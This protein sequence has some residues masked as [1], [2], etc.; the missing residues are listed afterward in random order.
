MNGIEKSSDQLGI[1]MVWNSRPP[2]G[3]YGFLTSFRHTGIREDCVMFFDE[4]SLVSPDE[5]IAEGSLVHYDVDVKED[6]PKIK[7]V[8]V[9]NFFSHDN[10]LDFAVEDVNIFGRFLSEIQTSSAPVLRFIREKFSVKDL[11]FL[12]RRRG[13]NEEP[14]LRNGVEDIIVER[15]NLIIGGHL[16]YDKV[17]FANIVLRNQT[18]LFLK[19]NPQNSELRYLNR[20]LLEDALACEVQDISPFPD[21]STSVVQAEILDFY[22]DEKRGRLK[23]QSGL[24]NFFY[25]IFPDDSLIPPSGTKVQC[26]IH[27]ISYGG[28]LFAYDIWKTANKIGATTSKSK[29]SVEQVTGPFRISIE[30]HTLIL[31]NR[32]HSTIPPRFFNIL[33]KMFTKDEIGYSVRASQA[34]YDQVAILFEKGKLE[35]DGSVNLLSNQAG[36]LSR[37]PAFCFQAL[38]VQHFQGSSPASHTARRPEND[39]P[40]FDLP[41]DFSLTDPE[42]GSFCHGQINASLSNSLSTRYAA[43]FL[44]EKGLFKFVKPVHTS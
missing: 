2:V 14:M 35:E 16:I 20:L 4:S 29:N 6:R 10:R 26:R 3:R 41:R 38:L 25:H 31:P 39:L 8:R 36:H 40:G 13:F 12:H 32:T 24:A 17:R 18:Q 27:V 28:L 34:P 11:G 33:A 5:P 15:L 42:H 44:C 19:K 22:D 30:N 21:C 43:L 23:L 1:V 9:E 37:C 7:N